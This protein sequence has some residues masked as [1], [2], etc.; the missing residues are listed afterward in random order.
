MDLIV[1]PPLN[2]IKT[3]QIPLKDHVST[4][5]FLIAEMPEQQQ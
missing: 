2:S 4:I 1:E 5:S 3:S